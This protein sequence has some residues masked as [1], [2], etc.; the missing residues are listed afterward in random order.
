MRG[1]QPSAAIANTLSSETLFASPGRPLPVQRRLLGQRRLVLQRTVTSTT[2]FNPAMA[3]L[4]LG[5]IQHHVYSAL[6]V[7]L[8]DWKQL[9]VP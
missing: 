2:S 6:C 7:E 9:P 3:A 8:V 4:P 5:K 1:I